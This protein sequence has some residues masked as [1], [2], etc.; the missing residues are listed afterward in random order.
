MLPLASM[1]MSLSV[2]DMIADDP[3]TYAL[4]YFQMTNYYLIVATW[5]V[6]FICIFGKQEVIK[7]TIFFSLN[8][9][10]LLLV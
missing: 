8:I 6:Y 7:S 1:H 5:K 10:T 3:T 4:R 9:F 2:V